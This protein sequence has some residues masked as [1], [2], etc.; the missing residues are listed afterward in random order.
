MEKCKDCK[1][2]LTENKIYLWGG[3]TYCYS[4]Y[5]LKLITS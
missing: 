3:Y 1:C 2:E 4:H 5:L